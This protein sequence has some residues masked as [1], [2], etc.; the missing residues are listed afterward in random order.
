MKDIGNE[1]SISGGGETAA[2]KSRGAQAAESGMS[3]EDAYRQLSELVKKMENGTLP[4]SDSVAA[5]EQATK[6]K[7]YCEQLLK[8][9]ETKVETV[10]TS[11]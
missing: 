10:G 2:D 9:A 6:L 5:Y 8:Q 4:L 7:T 1:S 3:F 11:Q